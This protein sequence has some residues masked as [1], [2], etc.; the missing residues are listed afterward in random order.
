MKN[1]NYFYLI[2][3]FIVVAADRFTKSLALHL[4]G[5]KIINQFL[6]FNLSFNRGI[7]WG[8]FNSTNPN[9][10]IFINSAIALVILAL[11]YYTYF[12]WK[13]KQ[14]IFGHILILAGAVSNYYDRMFHGGVIDFI[15]LSWGNLSWPSF[16]IADA[17]ICIGIGLFILQ[18]CKDSW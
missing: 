18:I 12:Y 15:V 11:V 14:P 17:A 1:Q 6:S 5:E 7:N 2:I 16:N 4:S 13:L 8:F 10:F 3:A 9:V